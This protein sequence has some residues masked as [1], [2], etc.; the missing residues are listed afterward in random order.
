MS[1]TNIC[2]FTDGASRGNPGAAAIG[3]I[4]YETENYQVTPNTPIVFEY[5]QSLGKATNSEAEWKALVKGL[6]ICLEKNISSPKFYLDSELV[7]NQLNGIYK[8]KKLELK[9]FYEEA[10][11]LNEKVLAK[12]FHVRREY[13]TAADALANAALDKKQKSK[14]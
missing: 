1:F 7:V 13:N 10:T 14:S 3:V 12:F 4:A 6:E 5:S 8:V 2:V 9:K 11:L